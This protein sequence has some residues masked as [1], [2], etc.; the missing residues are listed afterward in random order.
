MKTMKDL[1]KKLKE[2]A[3]EE[4]TFG[5]SR[6]KS[7]GNGILYTI[8]KIEEYCKNNNIKLDL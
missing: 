8:N 1:L 7:Y 2:Q 6:E 3:I 4:K 5:N